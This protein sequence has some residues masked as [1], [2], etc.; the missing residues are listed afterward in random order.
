MTELSG[1]FVREI[2]F[3]CLFSMESKKGSDIKIPNFV[4]FVSFV[5]NKSF[6]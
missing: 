1:F 2:I 5:V 3:T 6:P 4:L